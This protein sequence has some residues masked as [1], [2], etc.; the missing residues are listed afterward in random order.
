M[1]WC[2]LVRWSRLLKGMFLPLLVHWILLGCGGH[3]GSVTS[4][5]STPPSSQQT[6][7]PSSIEESKPSPV[8]SK[9]KSSPKAGRDAPSSQSAKSEEGKTATGNTIDPE[10]DPN[11]PAGKKS[12]PLPSVKED[13][14]HKKPYSE[15]EPKPFSSGQTHEGPPPQPPSPSKS[16][17]VPPSPSSAKGIPVPQSPPKET[18]PVLTPEISE[19]ENGQMIED[20][21][22]RVKETEK[23]L[24]KINQTALTKEQQD[25]LVTVQNFLSKAKEAFAQKDYPMALNL[26]EKA[27][28]LTSEIVSNSPK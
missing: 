6:S 24:T 12:T 28:T 14:L 17:S 8:K 23:L 4:A 9:Q 5:G 13:D 3:K 7:Q 19:K 1:R 11:L 25:T 27:H 15:K 20:F 18:P 21:T 26:A 22:T 16:S 2:R 10:A